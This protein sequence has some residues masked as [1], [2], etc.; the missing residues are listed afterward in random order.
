MIC[1]RLFFRFIAVWVLGLAVS[2]SIALAEPIHLQKNS[3][4]DVYQSFTQAVER[5]EQDYSLYVQDKSTAQFHALIADMARIR[6]LFDLSEVA[7][8]T[9]AR[10]GNNAI[11]YLYD[12]LGRIPPV[13][14][15]TIPG[16]GGT[17]QG[18]SEQDLPLRWVIPGTDIQVVRIEDGPQS[19][20][21]QF[22]AGSVAHLPEYYQDYIHSPLTASR[23]YPSLYLEQS[24]V[25]GPWIPTALARVFPAWLHVHYSNTPAWKIVMVAVVCVLFLVVGSIWLRFIGRLAATQRGVKRLMGLTAMPV[26]LLLLLY[27]CDKFITQ[28]LNPVGS[29]AINEGLIASILYYGL[30]AWLAWW[31]VYFLV[32]LLGV[33]LRANDRPYDEALLRLLAK[34]VVV[35]LVAFIL[36]QGADQLGIPALGLLAGFGVGGIAVAL[37]S[38]STIE[39]IFGG[40]SLFADRPFSVGDKIQFN[41]QSAQVLRIGPRST[42]LR[43][44]DGALCTLPNSDLAKMHIVNFSLRSSCYLNQTLALHHDSDPEQVRRLV[45]LIRERVLAEPLVEQGSGWPRVQLVGV[46][47]GR[48]EIC[49]RAIILS[50]DYSEYLAIQEAVMFDVLGYVRELDLKLAQPTTLQN[51]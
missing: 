44:R 27:G 50:T 1:M 28:Q 33:L 47:V 37:A 35:V 9:R 7:P 20:R 21:Y 41:N 31:L 12:I 13:D 40:L 30:F 17:E 22:A 14:L 11:A 19:G 48:I 24:N 38:Q 39:N 36:L 51:A 10:V 15:N 42:R 3:P 43:T 26:G 34:L 2:Q 8:A 49:I 45:P 4:F 18:V 32:E 16:Y 25:T 5:L 46:T 23:L 6:Q 29:F